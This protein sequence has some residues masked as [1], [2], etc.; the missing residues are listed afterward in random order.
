MAISIMR[1]TQLRQADLN[2]LVVFAVL[3]EERSVSRSASRLALSQPAVSRALQRLRDLFRDDLLIRTATGYEPTPK[4]QRMLSELSAILPRLDR[5]LAGADFD[6]AEESATFRIA[7]TDNAA[8]VICPSLCR[9]IL[10]ASKRVTFQFLAWHDGS[11]EEL[12]HGRL[13]LALN[14][15]DGHAP[16]RF[17]REV[18]YEDEFVCVVSKDSP[19]TRRIT[20][21]QYANGLH[22][23]IGTLAGRQTIPEQRL[24]ALG[25]QRTCVLEVP[26]FV[27][28]MRCIPGTDLIATLPKRL[29]AGE[30][31]DPRIRVLE[32]PPELT[33]FRYLMIWHPRVHTDAAHTWLRS[34]IR[35][36]C[37][38]GVL[39]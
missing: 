8:Q 14:A 38:K 34:A 12:E 26:Y 39:A 6:P 30:P 24:M 20:L 19:H 10:P 2:L 25:Y 3:A 7:C 37:R 15:D 28:A 23:G 29:M 13:D 32:P 27:A 17:H 36:A 21:K 18:I 1:L 11:L 22:I 9:T 16:E 31:H 33:G 35:Q 5:M 4:G